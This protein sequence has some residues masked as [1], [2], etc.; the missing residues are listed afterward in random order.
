MGIDLCR[1][2]NCK[3]HL[4]TDMEGNVCCS[5]FQLIVDRKEH[6]QYLGAFLLQNSPSINVFNRF[7]CTKCTGAVATM[8]DVLPDFP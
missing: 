7:V 4:P 2:T 3:N 6:T 5:H 8:Q 1:G